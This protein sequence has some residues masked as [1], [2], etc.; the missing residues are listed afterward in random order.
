MTITPLQLGEDVTLF[1]RQAPGCFFLV[2][3]GNAAK[4]I[5]A[6]HHSAE[7]DIDEDS[8]PIAAQIM[9]EATLAVRGIEAHR[10]R[11]KADRPAFPLG[12][13]PE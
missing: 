11:W 5:T 2:G 12:G 4:G 1:L 7:F 3:C 9:T 8:L 10:Q 13:K 6:S